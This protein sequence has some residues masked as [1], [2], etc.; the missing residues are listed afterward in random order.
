SE[1]TVNL[2]VKS[3]DSRNAA[4]A[5]RGGWFTRGSVLN[6][7]GDKAE[8]IWS[9][10]FQ[11]YDE[12]DEPQDSPKL[13]FVT[14]MTVLDFAGGDQLNN[15]PDELA[16]AVVLMMDETGRMSIE[17][18]LTDQKPVRE[19]NALIEAKKESERAAR[20]RESDGGGR[21]GYGGGRGGGG[22]GGRGGRGRGGF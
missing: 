22:G 9:N 21:G 20:E 6:F 18:E 8:I 11:P 3:L 1:P 14:G 5:A 16:P 2:I 19:Y 7:I 10:V 4:E 17:N 12:D 13:D 15:S